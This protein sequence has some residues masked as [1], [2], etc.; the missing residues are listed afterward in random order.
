MRLR[1]KNQGD[2]CVESRTRGYGFLK[3]TKAYIASLGTTGVLLAASILM[4]AVVSAVVAFDRW[5]GA[6][7]EAPA[8]TLVLDEQAPVIRVSATST[9]ASAT[10]RAARV[11][12]KTTLG[13]SN[14]SARAGERIA[15]GRQGAGAPATTAPAIP[16]VLPTAP[17]IPNAD[18]ILDPISS[19]DTAAS[20][21]ADGAQ[22]VTDTAGRSLTDVSPD[23]GTTV[24][25]AGQ[26][27]T[28]TLRDAALPGQV[29]PGH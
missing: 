10:P 19:P 6:N 15:S 29:I 20:Q 5:P 8:K 13:R 27:V 11:A 18:D 1:G 26:T 3:A 17:S 14:R 12:A 25:Q 28:D 22:S 2:V 9:A 7:V 24:T 23:V 21:I 16:T 4:L